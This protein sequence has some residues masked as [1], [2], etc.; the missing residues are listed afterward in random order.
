MVRAIDYGFNLD[1]RYLH[2]Y[3]SITAAI[4]GIKSETPDLD[5]RTY[6]EGVH[7]LVPAGFELTAD[8][9][10]G[11]TVV[12]VV[13]PENVYSM[14]RKSQPVPRVFRAAEQIEL[15]ERIWRGKL[16]LSLR[17]LAERL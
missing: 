14:R 6:N 10:S 16:A 17:S 3:R 1:H 12:T 8:L 9:N 15:R 13:V 7:H 5:A 2:N 4:R 11:H